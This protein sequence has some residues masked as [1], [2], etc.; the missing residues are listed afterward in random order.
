M[1][2]PDESGERR[3]GCDRACRR[4]FGAV[5]RHHRVPGVG[6]RHVRRDV[7]CFFRQQQDNTAAAPSV[8]HR[9]A[10]SKCSAYAPQTIDAVT[11]AP[12]DRPPCI[13]HDLAPIALH[14]RTRF[15]NVIY[16]MH[17]GKA[18]LPLILLR[19]G[20]GRNIA[21]RN[22]ANEDLHGHWVRCITRRKPKTF[23]S[24]RQRIA[25]Q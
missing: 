19:S 23:N 14:F 7:D 17:V 4:P 21:N 3:R 24:Q 18:G 13:S 11:G 12:A 10:R 20:C 25:E 5:R 9:D 6:R 22:I 1:R 2:T 16:G 8:A 15:P